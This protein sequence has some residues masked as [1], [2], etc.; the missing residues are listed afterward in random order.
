MVKDRKRYDVREKE[1][2]FRIYKE[3]S[4]YPD[5]ESYLK[6]NVLPFYKSLPGDNY[7]D[8]I[9]PE[10]GWLGFRIFVHYDLGVDNGAGLCN[11]SMYKEY[12]KEYPG[13]FAKRC[14]VCEEAAKVEE[15]ED[16][17]A[18]RI[19]SRILFVV[20]DRYNRESEEKGFQ[21]YDS[22]LVVDKAIRGF[23]EHSRTK[24]FIDICDPDT[25]S[26]LYFER[27]G[28]A[29]DLKTRYENFKL[30]KREPIPEKWLSFPC[31]SF[32]EFLVVRSY[33]EM[34]EIFFGGSLTRED[35]DKERGTRIIQTDEKRGE[36]KTGERESREAVSGITLV[37]VY[38]Y[39]WS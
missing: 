10:K 23:S 1:E 19:Q 34:A 9:P 7:I 11:M 38:P 27:K 24:E 30:E 17:K 3:K 6:D 4:D 22:P 26:T 15:E 28:K 35:K 29:G 39:L 36:R 18:L 31:N 13:I 21:L 32:M 12:E 25:G 20:V 33:E 8:I 2:S 14:P 5:R 37:P 16:K